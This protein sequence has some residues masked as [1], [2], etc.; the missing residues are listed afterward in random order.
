V[1]GDESDD[2]VGVALGG[3]EARSVERMKARRRERRG[4]P[5]VVQP[6]GS[7][8]YLS[9]RLRYSARQ[10]LGAGCHALNVDPSRS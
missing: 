3:E 4:V 2:S 7:D 5:N 9:V 8:E 6:R 10:L 1:V